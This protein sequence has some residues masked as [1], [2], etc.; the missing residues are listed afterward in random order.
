MPEKK[1]ENE[2][3]QSFPYSLY[4]KLYPDII[5]IIG[6]DKRALRNHFLKYGIKSDAPFREALKKYQLRRREEGIPILE[7]KFK[8]NLLKIYSEE[9]ANA[10]YQRCIDQEN[11]EAMSVI[12]FQEMLAVETNTF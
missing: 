2:P 1:L 11:L 8:N 6:E 9:K 12:E 7:K 3:N 10:I 4:K 5:D